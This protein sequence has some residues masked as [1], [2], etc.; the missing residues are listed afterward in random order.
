MDKLFNGKGYIDGIT[1]INLHGEILFTAKF[2]NK[3]NENPEVDYE[4]V[5]ENFLEIYENLT[6]E[7]SSTY[8]AMTMGI[9]IY[10]EQQM[11]K[12]KGR[13][14][15]V[16]TSLSIPIKSG[17][18]IVGGIDLSVSE[19]GDSSLNENQSNDNNRISNEKEVF[20]VDSFKYNKVET[21]HRQGHYAKYTLDNIITNNKKM[22]ELK[23][24]VKVASKCNLPTLI[25][26]ETGTGKELFAQ[27]IHNYSPR[28]SK[29]FISQNCAAIPENLLESILFGT[30]K[31][32]FTGAVDNIGLIEMANG[33]T[34]FLDE[35]NSMP[36]HLQPKLLRVLEEG[37]LRRIGSLEN[38]KIDVKIIAAM[39]E[40]PLR[41]IE[42]K[43][44]RRD[45]YYRLNA[46]NFNIPPLRDR[47]DDIPILLDFMVSKY[48]SM[49]KKN[50]Q[51]ITKNVLE[52]ISKYDWPGNIRELENIMVY[53][54][55][56]VDETKTNLEFSDIESKLD[57]L[58]MPDVTRQ[59]EL[60]VDTKS[61]K[62]SVKEYERRMIDRALRSTEYN[63]AKAAK[64]L[65]IPR[66][67]LQ[68]KVKD[69]NLI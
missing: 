51:Y 50:I 18:T 26:G 5:G 9:P 29:P 20:K 62:E 13:D 4:V 45:I 32:A 48:N 34:L 59:I 30:S 60:D 3:L 68:R 27:A 1:I 14:E 54:M 53:A 69:Y 66:Q 6:E 64:M 65:S 31:G 23:E 67:T 42:N 28:K 41:A 19:D 7:T 12:S 58:L 17:N 61:L 10:K 16:I 43:E 52:E 22:L 49:F 37:T 56:L 24:Y 35:I 15:I 36:L 63:I 47:K 40:E 21:L 55:S 57:E 33:G 44:L 46:I 39:N 8:K 25:Y 11:L 2:N 38:I